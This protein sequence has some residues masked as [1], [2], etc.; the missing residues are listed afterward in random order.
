MDPNAQVQMIGLGEA[1]ARLHIPYQDAHRLLLTGKLTG[2]KRKGR[3]FVDIESVK[4]M[5]LERQA[6]TTHADSRTP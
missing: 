6:A 3:W 1:A 5:E 2:Q 4:R